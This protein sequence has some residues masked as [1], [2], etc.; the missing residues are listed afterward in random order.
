MKLRNLILSITLLFCGEALI[1]AGKKKGCLRG[2]RALK[3]KRGKLIRQQNPDMSKAE[4]RQAIKD[5][6]APIKEECAE[7]RNRCA[8]I[9]RKLRQKTKGVKINRGRNKKNRRKNRRNNNS[10]NDTNDSNDN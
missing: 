4:R 3:R 7:K 2:Q 8:C 6:M 10:N 5:F 9:R 1:A